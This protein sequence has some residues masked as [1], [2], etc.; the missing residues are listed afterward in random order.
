M[1]AV[2][3]IEPAAD[4]VEHAIAWH[5]GD[6]RAAIRTLIEDVATLRRQLALATAAMGYGYTRG[7]RP[8]GLDDDATG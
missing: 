2:K 4:P 5:D 8:A 1:T 6:A 7:W 3:Q